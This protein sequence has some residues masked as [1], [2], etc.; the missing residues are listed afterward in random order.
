MA[1]VISL[2]KNLYKGLF[3]LALSVGSLSIV[4]GKISINLSTFLSK[5][6]N[7][8]NYVSLL[9]FLLLETSISVIYSS[10][11]SYKLHKIS[12]T[13]LAYYSFKIF[14]TLAGN[15]DQLGDSTLGKLS[16]QSKNYYYLDPSGTFNS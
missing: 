6:F 5:S 10:L 14:S 11:T 16:I 7:H 3:T 2:S 12:K 15:P 4:L 1:T 9:S 13:L 8:Y